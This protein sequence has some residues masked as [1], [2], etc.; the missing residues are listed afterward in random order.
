[1]AAGAP[2]KAIGDVVGS[3][4]G[5][6]D[7]AQ[8][9][10][11][12]Q[13]QKEFENSMAIRKDAREEAKHKSDVDK[14]DA[15]AKWYGTQGEQ[16]VRKTDGQLGK[17][18]ADIAQGWQKAN[19]DSAYKYGMLGLKG[20]ELGLKA[21]EIA[22]K[23]GGENGKGGASGASHGGKGSAKSGVFRVD[24][25]ELAEYYKTQGH[26]VFDAGNGVTLVSQN[27][28]DFENEVKLRKLIA[29]NPELFAEL[30]GEN[31]KK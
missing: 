20:D 3:L 29:E 1:M 7:E 26:H 13:K 17:W 30:I 23:Y 4:G 25:P 9:A 24:S 10:K 28:V 8:K 12:A 11:D 21:N 19:A 6:M 22:L 16:L 15:L 18:N 27:P 31:A 5:I 2:Y 14:N